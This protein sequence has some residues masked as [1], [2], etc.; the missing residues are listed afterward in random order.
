MKIPDDQFGWEWDEVNVLHRDNGKQRDICDS[1]SQREADTFFQGGGTVKNKVS[2]YS[3]TDVENPYALRSR[4]AG[5][6]RHGYRFK[7]GSQNQDEFVQVPSGK[8]Y[9]GC[10]GSAFNSNPTF[11]HN[12]YDSTP[13]NQDPS[14]TRMFWSHETGI[15]FSADHA[16]IH[17]D[18]S[19]TKNASGFNEKNVHRRNGL[20]SSNNPMEDPPQ[21]EKEFVPSN[22]ELRLGQPSQPKLSLESA[23]SKSLRSRLSARGIAV[24]N[25]FAC[26]IPFPTGNFASI[27]FL[28]GFVLINEVKL[29]TKC[30]YSAF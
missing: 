21:M 8:S 12:S 5:A 30:Y 24:P 18:G 26:E 27:T 2:R 28:Q 22:F 15:P 13:K 20:Q 4:S 11:I 1:S 7:P 19:R 3:T 25:S 14:L 6:G 17:K 16:Y 9:E 10:S 29:L 23:Y